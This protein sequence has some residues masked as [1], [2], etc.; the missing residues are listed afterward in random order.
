MKVIKK[1]GT[2]VDYDEQKIISAVYKSAK[3]ALYNLYDDDYTLICNKV[4]E[5]IDEENYYLEEYDEVLIPVF[6]MHDI[7]VKALEELGYDLKNTW[8]KEMMTDEE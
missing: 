8:L 2:I 1:D 4:A 7:V 6:D 3:R 5:I